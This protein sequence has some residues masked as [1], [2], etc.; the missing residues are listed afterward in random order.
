MSKVDLNDLLG[1][2]KQNH[3]VQPL[4]WTPMS[5]KPT[6]AD[7]ITLRFSYVRNGLPFAPGHHVI[8]SATMAM[9][10]GQKEETIL[11][12]L[13]HDI[14]MWLMRPDHGWWSAQLI[15][16]YVSEK[17]A[18][19]VRHHQALR[20]YPDP[21][22]GYEYPEMYVRLFGADYQPPVHIQTAYEQARKH[23][24]YME[25]RLIT[26]YDEYSFDRATPPTIEP[27]LDIIGRQFRQPEEGLGNDDS[28]VAHMWRTIA[29]PDRPI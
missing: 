5:A 1:E 7:F 12:C 27:F 28:P 23:P 10:S 16:P 25:S 22:V 19:A 9:R 4:T 2:E 17:V 13:L 11:A 14:G 8:Q 3:P 24:W 18:W 6:L 15:E 26:L 21:S 20:F 29:E